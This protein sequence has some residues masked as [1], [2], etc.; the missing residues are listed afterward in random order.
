MCQYEQWVGGW[1][2]GGGGEGG[3]GGLAET[4]ETSGRD[5]P[6]GWHSPFEMGGHNRR[7]TAA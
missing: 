3:E 4:K 5:D 2:W 7:V 6:P 1:V